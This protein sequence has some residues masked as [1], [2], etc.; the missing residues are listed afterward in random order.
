MINIPVN[1][2]MHVL[3]FLSI[4]PTLLMGSVFIYTKIGTVFDVFV[5][6]NWNDLREHH[7]L[8]GV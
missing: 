6:G 3:M 1:K 4:K 8:Y 2:I 5:A 7:P